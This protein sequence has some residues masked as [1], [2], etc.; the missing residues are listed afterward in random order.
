MKRPSKVKLEVMKAPPNLIFTETMGR[1]DSVYVRKLQE[2][3]QSGSVIQ[4]ANGDSYMKLQLRAAAK[5]ISAKLL[6]AESGEFIYV[7]AV[8]VEG[9]AK[10]LMLLLREGRTF[11]ELQSKKLEL[12]LANALNGFVKDG[13]AHE[14]RGKWVLTEKGMDA[15]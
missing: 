10:R 3:I 7:K 4:I 1:T 13:L 2:A 5:K 8:I 11:A 15:V 6:Y 14:H 12:H 9:E